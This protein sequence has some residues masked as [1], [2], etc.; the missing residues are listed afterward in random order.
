MIL[1]LISSNSAGPDDNPS[2]LTEIAGTGKVTIFEASAYLTL[3][4]F[5]RAGSSVKSD[6]AAAQDDDTSKARMARHRTYSLPGTLD[7]I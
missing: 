6:P 1:S 5:S 4:F 3:D 2:R 7:P